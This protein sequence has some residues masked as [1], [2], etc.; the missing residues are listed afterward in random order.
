MRVC[1]PVYFLAPLGGLQGYVRGQV[2]AF[3]RE[4]HACTVVTKPGPFAEIVRQEGATVLETDFEDPH[5]LAEAVAAGDRYDLVHA[6]P[7]RARQLGLRAAREQQV[8]LAVTFHGTYLDGIHFWG[9]DLDLMITVTEGSRDYLVRRR[10]LPADRIVVIPNGCDTRTYRRREEDWETVRAEVPGIEHLRA[11]DRRIVI[12][13]RFDWDKRFI[14]ESVIDTWRAMAAEGVEDVG[15]LVAGEGEYRPRMERAAEELGEQVGRRFVDFTGWVDDQA[16]VL[17]LSNSALAVAT[18]RGVAQ[19]MACETAV[20]VLGRYAYLGL[21]DR[22][23]ADRAAYNNFGDHG[24][25]DPKVEPGAMWRDIRAVIHDDA[26]LTRQAEG[27]RDYVLSRFDQD[28]LD[29]RL[30]EHS[31][32]LAGAV[33]RTARTRRSWV[34]EVLGRSSL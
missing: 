19:A 23:S 25:L 4:G 32:R 26:A 13:S 17:L 27:S 34:R 30:V 10:A 31:E 24:N 14:V 1:L 16:Q 15:W 6:H 18:S 5:G 33:P 2:R 12:A 3:V 22:D 29:A 20:A 7:F 9:R 8:P 11:S 21:I 28:L